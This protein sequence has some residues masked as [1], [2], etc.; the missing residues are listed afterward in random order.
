[1]KKKDQLQNLGNPTIQKDQ[2][3]LHHEVAQLTD[4]DLELKAWMKKAEF[5]MK[6]LGPINLQKRRKLGLIRTAEKINLII[7]DFLLFYLLSY[8]S[9]K[10]FSFFLKFLTLPFH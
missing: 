4:Q 8:E 9:I 2:K 1:M 6:V 7:F 5:Q 3:D 10:S